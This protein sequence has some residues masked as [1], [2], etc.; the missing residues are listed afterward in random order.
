MSFPRWFAAC[1]WPWILIGLLFSET[2][3]AWAQRGQ[4]DSNPVNPVDEALIFTPPGFDHEGKVSVAEGASAGHLNIT[5]A[6]AATG[7]PT[8]CRV[9]VVGA[10]G[11]FY[12][13]R[14][15]PLA[16]YSLNGKWPDTLAGNR[17]SKAPIRYFGHFFYTLGTFTVDVP[18]GL[19]RIEVWKGLEYRPTIYSAKISA[20]M[21]RDLTL[22]ISRVLA[23]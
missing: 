13:P 3:H 9:N 11:N 16:G 8:F 14:E 12:Q 20:G 23:T 2:S 10:D 5:I 1:R 15:N 6:D 22:T 21:T 19:A 7:K 4:F 17:P 18:E